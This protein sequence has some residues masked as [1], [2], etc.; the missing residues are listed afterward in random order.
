M[1]LGLFGVQVVWGLQNVNTSRIFQTLGANIDELAL[2][3]IA[4]PITGLFVQPVIGHL[5]D[6]TWGPLGRRRPYI[7]AGTL[8]TALA[9]VAMPLATTLWSACL[10]L[11]LLTAAINVAMEPFRALVADTLPEPRRTSAYALQVFFIGAGAVFA[12]ALPWMLNHWFG[13]GGHAGSVGI[14]YGIGAVV[15]LATV[16]WSVATTRERPPEQLAPGPGEV[17][18]PEVPSASGAAALT[19]SGI[20]WISGGMLLAGVTAALG[21][22]R[23][24]YLVAGIAALFGLLQLGAVLLRRRGRASIGMIVIVED[25]LHMPSVL[26][27]LAVVQFFTWFGMFALWVYAIPAVAALDFG[28]LDPASP[29][30]G[31]SADWVGILF[32]E[33][34]AVAAGAALLL[35]AITRRIGR[36]A[37]H[38]ICLGCGALGLLGFAGMHRAGDL[39]LPALGIGIAWAAIL[40]LPYA[41]LSDGVPARKMGVYMGIHNIFI[42][43][44]QLVAASIMGFVVRV[45]FGGHAEGALFTAAGSLIVGACLALTIP[46]MH[47]RQEFNAILH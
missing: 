30:Y 42:V 9:L 32:A 17:P 1:C 47:H 14:A 5:S 41:M 44:P 40:S 3:W 38:A 33:Y 39:W 22:A 13:Q 35:P 46:S 10:M 8:L 12:S 31:E 37:C 36:H 24:L 2:L 7:V 29:A 21:S 11:W 4:A 28:T 20:A 18:H 34:N 27:R 16:G 19:F 25:I 26:K 45:P 43:L 15:L 6:R 23:E